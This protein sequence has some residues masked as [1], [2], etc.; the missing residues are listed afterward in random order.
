[1]TKL[2]VAFRN[3]AIPPEVAELD[4]GSSVNLVRG[5]GCN[6]CASSR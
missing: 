3:F 4:F 5:V 1:M 2:L 6:L